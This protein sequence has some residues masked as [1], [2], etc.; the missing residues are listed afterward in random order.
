MSFSIDIPL[1]FL[2]SICFAVVLALGVIRIKYYNP[3]GLLSSTLLVGG[4]FGTF[5]PLMGFAMYR[6]CKELDEFPIDSF[7]TVHTTQEDPPSIYNCNGRYARVTGSNEAD[8]L[9]SVSVYFFSPNG[10]VEYQ[11]LKLDKDRFKVITKEE[12]YKWFDN[13]KQGSNPPAKTGD[14]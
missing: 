9:V 4:L 13:Q 10:K 2:I 6:A 5:V 14:S 12:F 3:M 1:P 7:V 11:N 8:G